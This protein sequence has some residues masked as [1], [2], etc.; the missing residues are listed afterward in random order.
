MEDRAIPEC[1]LRRFS[2]LLF[3]DFTC[4]YSYI[5]SKIT[6]MSKPGGGPKS[7]TKRPAGK[8]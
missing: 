3:L 7:H 8:D 6:A 2:L 5:D 1:V 4:L